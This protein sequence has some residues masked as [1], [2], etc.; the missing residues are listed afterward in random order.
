M[1]NLNA[2]ENIDF[3]TNPTWLRKLRETQLEAF[4]ARGFP[5]RQE[6][7]W[8]YLDLTSLAREDF[9]PLPKLKMP[10]HLQPE[11]EPERSTIV[12][13]NGIFQPEC[14]YI[15]PLPDGVILLP[16]SHAI[17]SYEHKIRPFF[18][19]N[20]PIEHPFIS[21]NTAFLSGGLFLYVPPNITLK[22]PIYCL[23][24]NQY[25]AMW[26]TRNIIV[27]DKNANA[28]ILE[29]FKGDDQAKYFHNEVIQAKLE[30]TSTLNYYKIQQE[31]TKAYHLS[32]FQAHQQSDSHL[33]TFHATLGGLI[34]RDDI[35]IKLKGKRARCDLKGFYATR[36]RQSIDH[37]IFT[38]HLA[39]KTS[40]YQ[41]YK[42]ILKD[43]SKGIFNGKVKV[44]PHAAKTVAHQSN[45][46]ILLSDTIEIDTKPELEIY[47]E[48][49]Q[50][51]HGATVGSLEQ[52]AIFY[53]QSRGLKKEQA[54]HLLIEAFFNE[55]IESIP[56]PDI[57]QRL[58]ALKTHELF[59]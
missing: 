20:N 57:I 37:H 31:S 22:N 24:F 28:S 41:H 42:G 38:E 23:H 48:D 39:E 32:N 50:C 36:I 17:Q 47:N 14:S 56:L 30:S 12:F 49:V 9:A 29:H 33:S 25:S 4:L 7:A 19:E 34:S 1:F 45:Q 2:I 40:S 53:L 5:T 51:S 6:E 18:E 55:L 54:I 16:L 3:P 8:K 44:Y 21:L 26:H 11:I 10:L 15:E 52:E 13:Y 58:K 59:E 43:R 27:L 35:Q 46:N